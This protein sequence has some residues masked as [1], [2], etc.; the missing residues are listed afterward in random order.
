[1]LLE[2]RLILLL[3]EFLMIVIPQKEDDSVMILKKK[4]QN[5]SETNIAQ[6]ILHVVRKMC[7]SIDRIRSQRSNMKTKEVFTCA[8]EKCH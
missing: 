2:K 4:H 8:N 7:I 1:M 6:C 3:D 5:I